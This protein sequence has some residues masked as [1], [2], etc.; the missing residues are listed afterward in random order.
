MLCKEKWQIEKVA[1]A[2]KCRA[3]QQFG[4]IA[5]DKEFGFL[6]HCFPGNHIRLDILQRKIWF[7][8][9]LA[10]K[11]ILSVVYFCIFYLL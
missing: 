7:C 5:G 4:A 10:V 1:H 9:E 3:A 8:T 11:T 2:L 6:P